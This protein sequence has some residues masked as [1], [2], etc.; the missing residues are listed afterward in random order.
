MS[1]TTFKDYLEKSFSGYTVSLTPPDNKQEYSDFNFYINPSLSS[2]TA[3]PERNDG[4]S[5]RSASFMQPPPYTTPIETT[6]TANDRQT[7]PSQKDK[8][9]QAVQQIIQNLKENYEV[10]EDRSTNSQPTE[11][12][13][14]IINKNYV[15]LRTLYMNSQRISKEFQREIGQ[16]IDNE[17]NHIYISIY[18]NK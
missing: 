4:V 8:I 5:S 10:Y 3:F 2:S 9:R 13:L 11:S 15:S 17:T 12:V 6:L 18:G 14:K 1:T 7:S 16:L